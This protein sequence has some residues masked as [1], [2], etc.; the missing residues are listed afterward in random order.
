MKI[1]PWMTI[2]LMPLGPAAAFADVINGDFSLG[3]VGFAT[4]YTASNPDPGPGHYTVGTNPNQFNPY[5]TSF[6]DHTTGDGLMMIVDGSM[7]SGQAIWSESITVQPQTNYQFSAYVASWGA[8]GGNGIDPSPAQLVFAANGIAIGSTFIVPA[9]NGQWAQFAGTFNSGSFST[10]ALDITDLNTV[11]NGN[12][13][14]L[15]D[16]VM[17]VP[18][19]PE[20]ATLGVLAMGGA[21]LFV[22]RRARASR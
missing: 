18:P 21:V 6:G 15:D 22:R 10:I 20:P 1:L 19:I 17:E 12:D 4:D 3:D 16:I 13:V 9:L 11:F 5:G 14:A 7:Q 2:V 8:P